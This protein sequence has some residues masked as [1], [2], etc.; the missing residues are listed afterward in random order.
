MLTAGSTPPA[1]D[2][3]R[4]VNGCR[5]RS[6]FTT[7]RFTVRCDKAQSNSAA[8][9]SDG[10]KR[11]GEVSAAPL[12]ETT[13][14][15]YVCEDSEV[16]QG[17]QEVWSIN[18]VSTAPQL[19]KQSVDS[20]KPLWTNGSTSHRDSQAGFCTEYLTLEPGPP[21]VGPCWF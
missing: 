9:G 20:F 17:H 5:K 11:L 4:V 2:R 6:G 1:S 10:S 16:V 21:G 7:F 13:K 19:G 15:A 14:T 8:G 18:A 12:T 3:P